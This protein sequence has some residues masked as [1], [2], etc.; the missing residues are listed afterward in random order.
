[1]STRDFEHKQIAF[2]FTTDGEKIKNKKVLTNGFRCDRIGTRSR[3][4][5]TEK[6]T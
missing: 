4:Q 3:E 5:S 1:M 6:N 2:V